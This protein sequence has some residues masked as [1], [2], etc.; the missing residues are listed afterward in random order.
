MDKLPEPVARALRKERD[1]LVRQRAEATAKFDR[2]IA[3]IDAY[4]GEDR[5]ATEFSQEV[6]FPLRVP[7]GRR[8][9][10]AGGGEAVSARQINQKAV[11]H[12]KFMLGG[13]KQLKTSELYA[14]IVA[15]GILL[16]AEDPE[17]RLVQLLSENKDIFQ[18]D[19]KNG[20]SLKGESSGG[21]ELS[22]AS[23]SEEDDQ[24]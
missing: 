19:R 8:M 20:W 10:F 14:G 23:A 24:Q 5:R 12:C 16:K 3:D 2:E 4:L 21:T 1:A 17:R 22:G 11:E 7:P 18:S 9:V 13:S 6:V 15:H